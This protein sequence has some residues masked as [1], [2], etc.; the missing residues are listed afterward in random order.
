MFVS[1]DGTRRSYGGS[2][3]Y[4]SSGSVTSD[5]FTGYTTD[6]SMIEYGCQ[7]Y[8]NSTTSYTTVTGWA[9]LPNGTTMTFNSPSSNFDM[10]FPTRIVDRHGNYID[11]TYEGGY[12]PAIDTIVDTLGRTIDFNYNGTALRSISGPGYNGATRTFIRFEYFHQT[13]ATSGMFGSPIT[14]TNVANTTPYQLKAIFYPT[15]TNGY[16]F[17]G[18]S[19]YSPCGTD[20]YSPYGIIRTV[21]EQRGMNWNSGPDTIDWGTTN[22]SRVYNFPTSA[23]TSYTDSPGYS[24]QVETAP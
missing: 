2:S 3:S 16:W 20:A 15:T 17:C 10:T 5:T 18:T 21:L 14:A 7:Y 4:Y 1:P 23:S 13:I 9:Q 22:R 24:T 12:G 19:Y 8:N 11:I 6:G